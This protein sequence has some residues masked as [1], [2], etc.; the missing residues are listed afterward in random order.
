MKTA[1]EY[2]KFAEDCR[3]LALKLKD[4]DDKRALQL[5]AVAWDKVAD[6]REARFNRTAEPHNHRMLRSSSGGLA[7]F[8]AIRRASSPGRGNAPLYLFRD[9]E[10]IRL[11]ARQRIVGI[12]AAADPCFR[13]IVSRMPGGNRGT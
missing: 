7:M 8:T 13:L 1:A 4:P 10:G 9:N 2:R 11:V 6:E 5:M 12:V 3:E